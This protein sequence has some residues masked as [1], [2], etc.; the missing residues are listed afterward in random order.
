V[1]ADKMDITKEITNQT[2][3]ANFI[4]ITKKINGGTN[5]LQDR[6]QRYSKGLPFFKTS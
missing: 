1:L 4:A 5:G 2:N 3:M 6:V